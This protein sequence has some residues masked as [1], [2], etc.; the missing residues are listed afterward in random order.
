MTF[1]TFW[2]TLQAKLKVGEYIKNWTA[3][4]G[5]LGD[6]FKVIAI[7]PIHVRVE[8]ELDNAKSIQSVRKS[9]FEVMHN[10]W[11]SYCSG[12][13]RRTELAKLTRVSKY[14]MSIIK[15]LDDSPTIQVA[16]DLEGLYE[17]A[18][19]L[20]VDEDDESAFPEGRESFQ[21]HRYLER[22]GK[23]P[24][25]AKAKRLAETGKL[26]CEVCKMD[27]H[28]FYGKLGDGFIEAHHTVPV[29]MLNGEMNTKVSDLALVCSNCHRM[30]H[31]GQKLLSI[32][33]LRVLINGSISYLT[34]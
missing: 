13:L 11:E 3:R 27:F 10:N 30:L 17:E 12:K 18:E 26:E 24:S 23:I 28:C 21:T 31:R 33:E 7:S 32:D 22:D 20:V 2:H 9:D 1:S 29:S 5:Y 34:P 19:T 16:A 15:H 8:I 6:Q 4:K 25:K 14:T